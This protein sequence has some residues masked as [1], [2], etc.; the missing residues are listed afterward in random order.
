[1]VHGGPGD[2]SC[3]YVDNFD[4]LAS[5]RPVILYDQLGSCYSDR[6]ENLEEHARLPRFVDEISAIRAELGLHDVHL[7][8]HSWGST[9]VLEYLLTVEPKGV[10]SSVFVGPLF[11]TQR[12]IA[13][14]TKLLKELPG[15]VQQAIHEAV[16]SGNFQTEEFKAAN[17]YFLSQFG[18][19]TPREQVDLSA[20]DKKPSG[21]S[22]LYNYMWGP[23]EFVST[24]TLLDYD[25]LERLSEIDLP[26]LFVVGQF[27]E[28]RPETVEYYQQ[29]VDGSKT[30]ILPDAGHMVHLDQTEMFNSALADFFEEVESRR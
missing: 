11:G 26:V 28:A 4:G 10:R 29:L 15:D 1:M 23:S 17:E 8:G 24:G 6:I 2:T 19:R 7:V 13:D 30:K 18:R 9:V 5:A 21:D 14:A 20:C 12:W 25:R 22:G 3:T 16:E 27:D